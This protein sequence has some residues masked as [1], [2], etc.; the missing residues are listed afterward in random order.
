MFDSCIS[1]Q[2][3]NCAL[4]AMQDRKFAFSFCQEEKKWIDSQ[5]EY[6]FR[7]Q[8]KATINHM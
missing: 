6:S 5:I 8:I 4:C 2:L 3:Y 7:L 1:L